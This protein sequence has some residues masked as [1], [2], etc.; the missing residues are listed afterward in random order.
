LGWLLLLHQTWR[1]LASTAALRA[2][3][4][5]FAMSSRNNNCQN[6][7]D[8]LTDSEYRG[9]NRSPFDD[10]KLASRAGRYLVLVEMKLMAILTC[11]KGK[12]LNA[13]LREKGK[14]SML[15]AEKGKN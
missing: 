6:T 12:V 10:P 7:A 13:N 8:K 15:T 9:I 3:W 5:C 2:I 1:A 11:E 4:R 14:C